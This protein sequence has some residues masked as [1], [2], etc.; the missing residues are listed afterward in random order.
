M[1]YW[2]FMT[3]MEL[4]IPALTIGLGIWL[5]KKPPS[6]INHLSGYRTRRSMMNKDSWDFAQRYCGKVWLVSGLIMIPAD[7]IAM[8][9]VLGKTKNETG[10]FSIILLWVQIILML[11]TGVVVESKLKKTFDDYGRR[12]G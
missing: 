8:I 6:K 12:R 1:G 2:I 5:I 4:L 7:I 10:I 11:L 9:T 3:V